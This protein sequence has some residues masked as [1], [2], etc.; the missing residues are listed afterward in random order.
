M[1][2]M[3][4]P[5]LCVVC[6]WSLGYF[7][8]LPNLFYLLKGMTMF[9]KAKQVVVKAVAFVGI[10]VIG[11]GTAMAAAPDTAAVVASITDGSTAA[12]V[13]GLAM[14]AAIG[15]VKGLKLIRRAF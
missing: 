3:R 10:A 5:S 11:T 15:A 8:L 13:V 14:L 4:L 9:K 7:G 12:A 2:L 1:T 6:G